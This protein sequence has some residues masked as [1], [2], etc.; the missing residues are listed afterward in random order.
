[1]NALKR[2]IG[3]AKPQI[4]LEAMISSKK[5]GLYKIEP[6]KL[7]RSLKGKPYFLFELTQNTD[8]DTQDFIG[9]LSINDE[10]D[11]ERDTKTGQYVVYCNSIEIGRF[12]EGISDLENLRD[13]DAYI[14]KI[15]LNSGGAYNVTIAVIGRPARAI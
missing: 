8:E 13:H 11:I 14:Q 12:A 6:G 3:K 2:L 10:I 15:E 5:I 7:Q 4:P 1:M 9:S